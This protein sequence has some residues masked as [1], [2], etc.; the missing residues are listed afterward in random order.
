MDSACVCAVFSKSHEQSAVQLNLIF[1]STNRWLFFIDPPHPMAFLLG[2]K[3]QGGGKGQPPNPP[4]YPH[5]PNGCP[6]W[7][8]FHESSWL[9]GA[10]RLV[11][12]AGGGLGGALRRVLESSDT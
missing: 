5:A 6:D 9:S 7:V 11:G 4:L 12:Q 3:S 10:G 8:S 1:S 2:K